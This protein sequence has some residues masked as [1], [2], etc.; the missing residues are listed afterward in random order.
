MQWRKHIHV[1][2]LSVVKSLAKSKQHLM[3][4]PIFTGMQQFVAATEKPEKNEMIKQK[5][6]R[7]LALII[8]M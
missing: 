6:T 7:L 4:M 1:I 2:F 3:N 8:D 5:C